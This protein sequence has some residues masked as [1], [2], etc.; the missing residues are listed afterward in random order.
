MSNDA[1]AVVVW[2]GRNTSGSGGDGG[3]ISSGSS[4]GSSG[5]SRSSSVFMRSFPWPCRWASGLHNIWPSIGT[6]NN[7]QP[8]AKT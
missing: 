6:A 3:D 4:A 2:S 5:S 8:T 7:N 1:V